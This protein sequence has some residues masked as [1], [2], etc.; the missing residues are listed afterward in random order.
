VPLRS[1][2]PVAVCSR[3][4]L[5]PAAARAANI[6]F[7][8][9]HSLTLSQGEPPTARGRTHIRWPASR[10]RPA[11]GPC[12]AGRAGEEQWSRQPPSPCRNAVLAW[13]PLP[14]PRAGAAP[15]APAAL[16]SSGFVQARYAFQ[17]T[18]SACP[19]LAPPSG[20]S[21]RRPQALTCSSS[22]AP[23]APSPL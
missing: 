20:R 8:V 13:A 4:S 17:S 14:P 21:A 3:F 6:P 11:R 2:A 18:V 19:P 23:A 9:P 10:H 22:A 15:A 16:S 5:A 7:S 12:C 1:R